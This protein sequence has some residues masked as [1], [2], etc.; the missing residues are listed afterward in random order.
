VRDAHPRSLGWPRGDAWHRN[1][2]QETFAI[3]RWGEHTLDAGCLDADSLFHITDCV[4][5]MTVSGG[6]NTYSINVDSAIRTSDSL[7]RSAFPTRSTA[8]LYMCWC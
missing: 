5:H 8:R 4:N 7:R 1:K 6:K 2:H 3:L